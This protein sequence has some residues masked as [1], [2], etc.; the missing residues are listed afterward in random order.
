MP[1][2]I[3]QRIQFASLSLGHSKQLVKACGLELIEY[4]AAVAAVLIQ[5]AFTTRF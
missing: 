2:V 5:Q 4:L 1:N 3:L